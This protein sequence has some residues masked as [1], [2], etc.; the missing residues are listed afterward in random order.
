MNKNIIILAG[1][2]SASVATSN[3]DEYGIGLSLANKRKTVNGNPP[4]VYYQPA[5]QVVQAAPAP[6]PAAAP[7]AG[8]V[9]PTTQQAPQM[10]AVPAGNGTYTLVPIVP[11]QPAPQQSYLIPANQVPVATEETEW[12]IGPRLTVFSNKKKK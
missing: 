12:S 10:V 7:V 8:S 3:A 6:A 4:P 9:A 1:F 2:M 5:A 11:L